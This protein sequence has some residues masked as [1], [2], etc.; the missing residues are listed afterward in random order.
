MTIPPSFG[1]K[2]NHL[3]TEPGSGGE[4]KKQIYLTIPTACNWEKTAPFWIILED[5]VGSN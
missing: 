2:L 1:D 4:L 3:I 5:T